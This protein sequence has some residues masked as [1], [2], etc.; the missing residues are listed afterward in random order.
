MTDIVPYFTSQEIDANISE[1]R[2]MLIV[3][4]RVSDFIANMFE[5]EKDGVIEWYEFLDFHT[6]LK[7]MERPLTRERVE[8]EMQT[9][10]KEGIER[11]WSYDVDGNTPGSLKAAKKVFRGMDINDDGVLDSMELYKFVRVPDKIL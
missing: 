6:V 8:K 1:V 3:G 10:R 5:T 11:P 4:E 9:A 2:Q 7:N